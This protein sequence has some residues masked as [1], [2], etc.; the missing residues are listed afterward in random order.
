MFKH[1][2]MYISFIYTHT[3][4]YRLSML[5]KCKL[6][7]I[8]FCDNIKWFSLNFKRSKNF[9]SRIYFPLKRCDPLLDLIRYEERSLKK[10]V[11]NLI[12][13]LKIKYLLKS[14]CKR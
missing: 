4:T 8:R 9:P 2:I 5:I 13:N 10:S 6:K 11:H 7:V 1:K 14:C 12:K 3:N